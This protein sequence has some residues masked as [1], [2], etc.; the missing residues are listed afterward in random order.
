MATAYYT[1]LYNSTVRPDAN[2]PA[3]LVLAQFTT[4]IGKTS[5]HG[6]GDTFYMF[7]LPKDGVLVDVI[8]SGPA[9]SGG[10]LTVGTTASCTVPGGSAVVA[11]ATTII[12]GAAV[13]GAWKMGLTGGYQGTTAIVQTTLNGTVRAGSKA[14]ADCGIYLTFASAY[15]AA[16]DV[17][18]GTLLYFMDY[19]ADMT[20]DPG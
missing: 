12:N 18:H 7:K 5:N 14:S 15:P 6:S 10:T 17:I 20:Y 3:G 4:F 19:G 13:T 2:A 1:D 16:D 11:G 8:L 9:I